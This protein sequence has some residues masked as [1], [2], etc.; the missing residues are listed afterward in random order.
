MEAAEETH[1]CRT[2][3]IDGTVVDLRSVAELRHAC[4][5]AV[6]RGRRSCCA[7]YEVRVTGDE[8][9]RIAGLMPAASR[10]VPDLESDGR[11]ENVFDGLG[12]EICA[13]ETDEEGLC[14]FAYEN[15]EGCL[16]CGLHS[17]AAD[18]GLD[19]Y[20]AKPDAC[21][22]WPLAIVE[23]DPTVLS[24]QPDAYGFPCNTRRPGPFAGLDPG[25]RR[26]IE[27]LFGRGFASELEEAIRKWAE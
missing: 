2:A 10:Y 12:H 5:P 27:A 8:V 13:L 6:C 26:I 22:L 3:C 20:A 25:V 9:P 18:L 24:V 15:G 23:T 21:T 14:V 16:L 17:A 7:E 4:D 11:L 19:P 1:A